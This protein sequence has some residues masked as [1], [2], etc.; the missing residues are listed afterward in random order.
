[1]KHLYAMFGKVDKESVKRFSKKRLPFYLIGL[2]IFILFGTKGL[3]NS[4]FLFIFFIL[5]WTLNKFVSAVKDYRLTLRL[6]RV[7]FNQVDFETMK[8]ERD[9]ALTALKQMTESGEGQKRVKAAPMPTM[10]SS[11][12]RFGH[13]DI[14]EMLRQ[15]QQEREVVSK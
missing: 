13:D 9:L 11:A 4:I 14:E 12:Q 2:L 15:L 10:P 5:G 6:N 8:R 1:M 7:Q 3:V